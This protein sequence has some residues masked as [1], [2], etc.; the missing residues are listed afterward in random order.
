MQFTICLWTNTCQYHGKFHSKVTSR[1][2]PVYKKTVRAKII[3]NGI[4]SSLTSKVIKT[5][6][7]C[8]PEFQMKVMD[9]AHLTTPHNTANIRAKATCSK[10]RITRVD[11]FVCPLFN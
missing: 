3:K 6:E 2:K 4:L 5:Q 11:V 9:V 10:M 8:K 7:Q 1:W